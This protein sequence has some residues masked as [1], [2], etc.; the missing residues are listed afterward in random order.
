MTPICP[1]CG[2]R[3]DWAKHNEWSCSTYTCGWGPTD[4]N[5]IREWVVSAAF[6]H[7]VRELVEGELEGAGPNTD[8]APQIK[9]AR[10]VAAH[11]PETDRTTKGCGRP[12]PEGAGEEL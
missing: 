1:D 10:K 12:R 3:L 4:E 7:D 11:L 8:W 9:A 5:P 6:M 2:K